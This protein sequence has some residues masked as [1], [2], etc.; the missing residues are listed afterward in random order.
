M[1]HPDS[2]LWAEMPTAG[3]T[4]WTKDGVEYRVLKTLDDEIFNIVDYLVESGC[5]RA[6]HDEQVI[7]TENGKRYRGTI[8]ATVKWEEIS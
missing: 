2:E 5:E 7:V 1:S 6:K 4:S 8:V 3:A